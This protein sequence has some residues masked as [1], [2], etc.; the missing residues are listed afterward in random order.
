MNTIGKEKKTLSWIN[1]ERRLDKIEKSILTHMVSHP[2]KDDVTLH[3]VTVYR[4]GVIPTMLLIERFENWKHKISIALYQR[5]D[6]D[7]EL[8]W[9]HLSHINHNDL[10]IFVDDIFDTGKTKSV[11]MKDFL[12]RYENPN[13]EWFHCYSIIEYVDP[14][15]WYIFPWEPH[16]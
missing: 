5:L 2:S 13:L 11:I 6:G 1:V 14:K 4:G 15:I 16:K 12:D 8:S 3:F 9:L 10:V 7:G